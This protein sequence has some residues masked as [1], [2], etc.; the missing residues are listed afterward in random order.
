MPHMTRLTRTDC[1]RDNVAVICPGASLL[2]FGTRKCKRGSW[3]T[4]ELDDHRHHGR[5]IGRVTC[6]G[7]IWI[8]IAQASDGFSSAY[9]RWIDPAWVKEVRPVP[10]RAVFAFFAMENWNPGDVFAA[11]DYG[12]SDM[13]DQLDARRD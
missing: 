1:T 9:I 3:V 10:P 8:E 6:E 12:V 2:G 5:A 7:R 13:R 11:L 4:Y